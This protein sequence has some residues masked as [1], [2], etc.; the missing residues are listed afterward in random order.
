MLLHVFAKNGILQLHAEWLP[1]TPKEHRWGSLVELLPRILRDLSSVLSTKKKAFMGLSDRCHIGPDTTCLF[2]LVHFPL[3]PR[4]VPTCSSNCSLDFTMYFSYCCFYYWWCV[5]M[6]SLSIPSRSSVQKRALCTKIKRWCQLNSI[7][8]AIIYH[9][10][11][12]SIP[13]TLPDEG[14]TANITNLKIRKLR[15]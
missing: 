13:R 14:K 15:F 5:P 2:S 8:A 11:N 3:H 6:Q 7:T 12:D 1:G 4:S 10:N 9:F